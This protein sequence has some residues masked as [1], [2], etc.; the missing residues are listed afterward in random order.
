MSNS[1]FK[2]PLF[3]KSHGTGQVLRSRCIRTSKI[4]ADVLVWSPMELVHPLYQI[5][6]TTF[7]PETPRLSRSR[8]SCTFSKPVP[9]TKAGGAGF[10]IPFSSA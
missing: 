2:G 8:A 4:K 3:T 6:T 9:T 1:R 5:S 10:K 7:C